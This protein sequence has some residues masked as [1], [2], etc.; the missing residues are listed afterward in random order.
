MDYKTALVLH[1]DVARISDASA[2][3]RLE[4]WRTKYDPVSERWPLHITLHYPFPICP[5]RQAINAMSDQELDIL[6]QSLPELASD[7]CA[8]D[9]KSIIRSL[10]DAKTSQNGIFSLSNFFLVFSHARVDVYACVKFSNRRQ[11]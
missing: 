2:R 5:L 7:N 4:S 11:A 10:C 3:Q 1:L 6:A 9:H 8:A